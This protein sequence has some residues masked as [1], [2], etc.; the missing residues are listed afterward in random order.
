MKF[1]LDTSVFGGYWDEIFKEDTI[2][3]LEYT[4][5]INAELIYSNV[6]KEELEGAPEK[7]KQL[8]ENLKEIEGKSIKNNR[9]K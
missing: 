1:Y 9:N 3:F 8:I 2:A 6:T 4:G 5:K 7:V